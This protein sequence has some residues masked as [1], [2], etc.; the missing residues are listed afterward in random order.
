MIDAIRL[1]VLAGAVTLAV[2]LL[3]APPHSVAQTPCEADEFC[4]PEVKRACADD[5]CGCYACH[6]DKEACC[7]WVVQ[8]TLSPGKAR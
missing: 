5:P 8:A 3:P 4:D 1:L 7:L 6:S 2:A